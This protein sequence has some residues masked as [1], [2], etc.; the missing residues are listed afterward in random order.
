MRDKFGEYQ[1]MTGQEGTGKCWWCGGEFPDKRH[2][3]YC[4]E[5]CSDEYYRH[6]WWASAT[7]WALERAN[8]K[9]QECGADNSAPHYYNLVVHHIEPLNNETRF[10]NIK[11]RPENLIVLCRVCHAKAHT[12]PANL[13]KVGQLSLFR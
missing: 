10:I 12:K 1:I 13:M 8:H 5:N 7:R 9:C 2:R 4:S 3:R 11:N 6:F